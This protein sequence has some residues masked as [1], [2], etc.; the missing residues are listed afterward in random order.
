[1]KDGNRDPLIGM[2][3]VGAL[4]MTAANKLKDDKDTESF[5]RYM[6]MRQPV[7]NPLAFFAEASERSFGGIIQ[8]T[9]DIMTTPFY[10]VMAEAT[11]IG[12][13][14]KDHWHYALQDRKKRMKYMP[15]ASRAR[16]ML[17]VR[18]LFIDL[19]EENK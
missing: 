9:M 16:D 15:I 12:N 2:L 3:G 17:D 11:S 8:P 13:N 5:G 14:S 10:A 7:I 1:M 6:S 18:D 19:Y 4:W